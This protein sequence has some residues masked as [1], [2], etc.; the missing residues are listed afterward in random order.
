MTPGMPCF[1]NTRKIANLAKCAGNLRFLFTLSRLPRLPGV[2][3]A[4]RGQLQS[5]AAL[6]RAF[7][8]QDLPILHYLLQKAHGWML[9]QRIVRE[10]PL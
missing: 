8:Q 3:H 9:E 7:R 5:P 4:F 10:T 6:Q 1:G 2:S